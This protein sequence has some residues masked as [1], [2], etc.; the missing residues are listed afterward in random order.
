MKVHI[1]VAVQPGTKLLQLRYEP[2]TR[3]WVLWLHHDLQM[4]HGTYLRLEYD[5]HIYSV[6]VRP[7]GSE[8]TFRVR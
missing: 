6:T 1:P 5:G 4:Q 2:D 8:D 3:T 7:D